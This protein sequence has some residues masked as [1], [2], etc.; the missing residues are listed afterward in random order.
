MI[1]VSFDELPKRRAISTVIGSVFFLVL[2]TSGLSISYLVIETQSDMIEAQQTIADSEIKK[3]QEKFYTSAST[4]ANNRLS[5]YV[6]NEGS[7][8]LEID[9]IWIVNKTD[10]TQNAQKYDINYADALLAPGYGVDIL[11]NTPLFMEPGTYDVKV[12]SSLGTIKTAEQLNVGG[13]NGLKVK[14]ILSPPDVR[15]GENATAVL[16]V[17]NIGKTR[18]LNVT[19]GPIVTAPSSSVIEMSP[20]VQSKSNL[21]PTESTVLSWKY[22]LLG[23]AGTN[24][25]FSTF[26]QG[27]DEPTNSTVQSNQEL[28]LVFLRD[29]SLGSSV[30]TAELFARPELFLIFPGPFGDDDDR[31][32][33][34]VNVVNP[35]EQPIYVNKVVI[36]A[37]TPRATSS[38]AIFDKQCET[39]NPLPLTVPPT[40]NNW[41]CPDTNILIWK[42]PASPQRVDPKSVFPFLVKLPPGDIGSSLPDPGAV[43]VQANVFSTLGQFGKAG[44]GTTMHSSNGAAI[45]SVYL[46]K[47]VDSTA[48]SNMMGNVTGIKPGDTVTF[49]AV[50]ADL[51]DESSNKI[52]ANSRLIINIPRGWTDPAIISTTGFDTIPPT[53]FPDG[54]SQIVGT[55]QADLVGGAKTI[56]F[57]AKAPPISETK[58][59]VMYILA[60]GLVTNNFSLGPLAEIVLRVSSN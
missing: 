39:K 4:G 48:A 50:F 46:S 57:T 18:I 47:V 29:E 38:D 2:M 14:L 33:W 32:L 44:Y 25:T 12:V 52:F 1:N 22:R 34:G 55:L 40:P 13:S 28:G 60:D 21:A 3:I 23:A 20:I 26:A 30:I 15:L 58:M 56:T 10:S 11:K 41:S 36:S 45:P 7:N 31:G 19:S 16:F 35:T 27:I 37:Q 53:T 5:L 6:E 59:Y 17:T 49:N 9:N 42:N 24:V 8:T 51:D 54:S 43:L